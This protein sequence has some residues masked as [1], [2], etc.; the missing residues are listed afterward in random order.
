MQSQA[1][2]LLKFTP[3][4]PFKD[5]GVRCALTAQVNLLICIQGFTNYSSVL[6]GSTFQKAVALLIGLMT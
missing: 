4:G 5:K 2:E 3:A 6:L 1:P